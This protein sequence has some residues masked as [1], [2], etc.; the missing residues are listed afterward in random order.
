[1]RC[2]GRLCKYFT[3]YSHHFGPGW[4]WCEYG[5]CPVGVWCIRK[6]DKHNETV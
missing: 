5:D 4:A 2:I 6:E 1:M 3:D